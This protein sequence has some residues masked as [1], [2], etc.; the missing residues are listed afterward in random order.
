MEWMQFIGFI[1]TIGGLF[2]WSR[3]E[4]NADRREIHSILREMQQEMKDFHGR[5]ISLEERY[6]KMKNKENK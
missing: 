1:L 4:S 3:T 2:F 6:L 5:L